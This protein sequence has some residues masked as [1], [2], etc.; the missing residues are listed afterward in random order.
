[1]NRKVFFAL[2]AVTMLLGTVLRRKKYQYSFW[3][4]VLLAFLLVFGGVGGTYLFGYLEAGQW[5]NIS[6]YGS[7]F[8]VPILMIPY[9]I[10]MKRNYAVLMDYCA[11]CGIAAIAVGKFHCKLNG[12]CA[13]RVLWH[14]AA[15]KDVLFPSQLT[16]MAV[17]IVILIALLLIEKK[18]PYTGKL[19]PYFLILYGLTRFVLNWFRETEL[20]FGFIPLSCIISLVAVIIGVAWLVI[21]FKHP[22]LT[23]NNHTLKGKGT[24]NK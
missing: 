12:C 13:G 17:A 18:K 15:G 6:Y 16:E 11:P 10:I 9:S 20:V 22:V 4:A 3:N 5:G 21:A 7:V 14:S 1:M 19:Y 8:F 24:N 23:K 2:L